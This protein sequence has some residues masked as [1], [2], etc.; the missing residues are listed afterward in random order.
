M[1]NPEFGSFSIHHHIVPPVY[2]TKCLCTY[3]GLLPSSST[4]KGNFAVSGNS[5]HIPFASVLATDIGTVN[6]FSFTP[7]AG[8][9]Y[10]TVQPAGYSAI[11]SSTAPYFTYRVLG[12]KI[13]VD[14]NTQV[15]S[16]NLWVV[17]G[18]VCINQNAPTTI[19]TAADAPNSTKMEKY[20]VY[21]HSRPLQNDIKTSVA[22]GISDQAVRDSQNYGALYNASPTSEWCHVINYQ[23][24]DNMITSAAIGFNIRVEYDIEFY[25]PATGDLP[26]T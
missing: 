16:D 17:L 1:V 14:V 26:D 5:A 22:F 11:C 25:Q 10:S 9:S 4:A 15:N 7:Y 13:F 6:T 23:T 20:S 8:E 19:W 3:A 12:S 2:R 24:V 21:F 18:T